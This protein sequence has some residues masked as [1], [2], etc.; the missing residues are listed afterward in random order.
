MSVKQ[1]ELMMLFVRFMEFILFIDENCADRCGSVYAYVFT[2]HNC[3][4]MCI[5]VT[6]K[7]NKHLF[8]TNGR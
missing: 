3:L 4:C 5:T 7:N 1:A 6:F 8:Q 2:I